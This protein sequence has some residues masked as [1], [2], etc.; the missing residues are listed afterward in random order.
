MLIFFVE[1]ELI[2]VNFFQNCIMGN[3]QSLLKD[4]NIMKSLQNIAA[5]NP[6]VPAQCNWKDTSRCIF[7][8]YTKSGNI[9]VVNGNDNPAYGGLEN[10]N[11]DQFINWLQAL[12][13]RNTG[14]DTSRGEA[15]NVYQYW[16]T[17]KSA[18]GYEFL[19]KLNFLDPSQNNGDLI[20]NTKDFVNKFVNERKNN[21]KDL[22]EMELVRADLYKKVQLLQSRQD[23]YLE[24]ARLNE[25]DN[26]NKMDELDKDISV[27]KRQIMY[28][29]ESDMVSNSKIYFLGNITFYIILFIIGILLYRRFLS[30]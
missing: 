22:Q 5:S 8:D 1:K 13:N 10:Y 4:P 16:N 21:F 6:S 19:K 7:K 12:Y 29:F 14:N 15:A 25:V 23:L 20:A 18:P 2:I 24:S 28:D 17:C 11:E 3:N 27:M 9:C 30:E 26:K